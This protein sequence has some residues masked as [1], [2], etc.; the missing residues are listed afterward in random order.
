[1][2]KTELKEHRSL[3]SKRF[4]IGDNKSLSEI[5]TGHI[6]YYNKLGLGDGVVGFR[7]IDQNLVWDDIK[8]GWTF[9]YHSYQPFFPEFSDGWAEFRDLFEDKDQTI[10]YKAICDRVRGVLIDT[11]DTNPDF[12]DNPENRCV[13]YANAFGINKD[14]LLYNK[15]TKMVKVATVNNPNEQTGDTVFKWEVELPNKEVFRVD[16]PI[17]AEEMT[18]K[19]TQTNTEDGVLVGYRLDITRSKTFSTNKLTLIGDSQL[20]GKEWY[21]HL[22]GYKA[23]DS[24]GNTID[25]VARLSIEDGKYILTKT[26]PLEFLQNAVGRVFTDT[27]TSFFSGAGD[28]AVLGFDTGTTPTQATWDAVH[29]TADP[30]NNAISVT[31]TNSDFL[32]YRFASGTNATQIGRSFYPFD[33]SSL[34]DGDTIDSATFSIYGRVNTFN[35]G[36]TLEIGVVQTSQASTSTLTSTDFDQ[37]GAINSP[38]EGA[39]RLSYTST[40]SESYRDFTLN[41]TG[42]T[43]IDKTGTTKLGVRTGHDMDDILPGTG[44]E[45]RFL[46]YYSEQTGTSQDPVL[47]VIHSAVGPTFI[48]RIMM[49]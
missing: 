35:G 8:K 29:D 41:S 45:H 32:K 3:T 37:C 31:T 33:T 4:D 43:W 12:G 21:T 9:L 39:T 20:D 47:E 23:W 11:D 13:V 40:D 36:G 27:T 10:E 49:S 17:D 34:P 19:G 18:E 14:Y 46:S 25:I 30:V 16:K 28:G 22:G 15:R 44:E 38:T 42:L 24:E 48:P 7:E 6:H 2:V 1:M 5:R 26:I